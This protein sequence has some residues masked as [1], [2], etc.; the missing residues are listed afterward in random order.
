MHRI[1][2]VFL[3][4]AMM[5]ATYSQGTA[6]AAPVKQIE[7]IAVVEVQR[8]ITETAEGIRAKKSLESAFKKN[9]SKL[10]RKT[11]DLQMYV[12]HGVK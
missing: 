11:K 3:C 6:H 2:K 12:S 9:Q 7:K 10:D 1:A 4:A 8:C 5:A